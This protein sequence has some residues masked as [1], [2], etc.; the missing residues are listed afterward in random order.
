[1]NISDKKAGFQVKLDIDYHVLHGD[2]LYSNF[3]YMKQ[4]KS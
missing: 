3:P 1:M 4:V 2:N